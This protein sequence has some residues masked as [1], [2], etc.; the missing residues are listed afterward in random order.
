MTR[1]IKSSNLTDYRRVEKIELDGYKF[2]S[3]KE[4]KFY[5]EL[6][7]RMLAGDIARFKLKPKFVL[8]PAFVKNGKKIR[9]ITY[10]ADFLIIN[11]DMSEE[12]IDIKG[13]VTDIFKIKKKI[14]EYVFKDKTLKIVK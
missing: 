12:I 10:I 7:L 4:A 11:N 5:Q 8:Q 2:D 14:F 13:F 6:K 9:A 3:K 1:F